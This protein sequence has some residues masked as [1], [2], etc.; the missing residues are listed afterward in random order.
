MNDMRIKADRDYMTVILDKILSGEFAIPEFQRDFVWDKRQMMNLFDSIIKGYPIGSIILWSP[1]N[2]E[3]KIIDNIEGVKVGQ[4]ESP[5]S[6]VLDGRQRLTTL[7]SIM[8]DGGANQD[9]IY[10]DLEDFKVLGKS[11]NAPFLLKLSDAFDSYCI[12]NYIEGLKRRGTKEEDVKY[13][14]DRAK[15]LNRILISY[16]IG[17]ITVSGG[18]IDD[19]V[20]IFSRLNSQGTNISADFMIQAKT[21]DPKSHFLFGESIDRILERIEEYNF[22]ELK[23]DVLLKCVLNFTNKPFID[24]KSEDIINLD[25]LSEVMNEVKNTV[26]KAV[27][28]LYNECLVIDVRLLPY[29]YQ[30]IA[31]ALFF[32]YNPQA[33][34]TQ[35]HEL[36]KWFYYTSYTNYFTNSSL[37]NIRNDI[38][39]FQRFSK[40]EI[41]EPICY[42]INN[43]NIENRDPKAKISLGSVNSCCLVLSEIRKLNVD[44]SDC[45]LSH[46]VIP[47]TGSKCNFNTIWCSSR[48]QKKDL[49][50][51][52]EGK[53]YSEIEKYGFNSEMM[54]IYEMGDIDR[55]AKLRM[56]YIKNEEM[57]LIKE[58]FNC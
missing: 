8:F 15:K 37:T 34:S 57:L 40:G 10:V 42:N 23:R 45:C 50:E 58:L 1:R 43:I 52:F 17:F 7:I 16:E 19:A 49:K 20:E 56:D 14:A 39:M 44:K 28:F 21:F 13:Y 12:V 9:S 54:R 18:D 29:S 11:C 55:F 36:K 31:L 47:N 5:R 4:N 24:A 33:N 6:Y 53:C 3:F 48:K 22:N 27:D 38:Y 51:I 25:N 30:L 41:S 2:E 26:V 46:Y 32:K 35:K